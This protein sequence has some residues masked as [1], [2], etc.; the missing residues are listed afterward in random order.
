MYINEQQV[1]WVLVPSLIFLE[2]REDAPLLHTHTKPT[3][4]KTE[5]RIKTEQ[6]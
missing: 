4:N 5:R 3:Q 6:L 2:W 1:I